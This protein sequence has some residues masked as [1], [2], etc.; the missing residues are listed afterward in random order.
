MKQVQK[1]LISIG[2]V[3]MI[4]NGISELLY[5]LDVFI[6]GIVASNEAVLASYKV[7]TIIPTAMAFIPLSLMTYMYPY[8]AEHKDDREW[9]LSNYKKILFGFGG[10]NLVISSILFLGANI[11]VKIIFG[12]QYIDAVPV[13]RLL[14]I[15]YFISGTFRIISG[16]LLV[17]Q[18]KLKFNTIV[19]VLSG[20][21]NV[22]ADYFFI[23][24]WGSIGA[25]LA[26]VLVVVFSSIMNT[27]YLIY[28]FRNIGND[29]KR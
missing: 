9:C 16:N 11:F 21:V 26:T 1:D 13:F 22:I 4:N 14:A 2:L 18:R 20:I 10:F 28:T 27:T 24:F 3:S 19:A 15:N 29:T 6:L 7:A 23:Q 12:S 5:L 8:F 17:T 25:A